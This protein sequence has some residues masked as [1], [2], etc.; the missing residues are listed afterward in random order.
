MGYDIGTI[1]GKIAAAAS[2]VGRP[3]ARNL[4]YLHF[5]LKESEMTSQ[6]KM[7]I[8]AAIA[9]VL[10]PNDF[11]PVKVFRLVGITDDAVAVMYVVRKVRKHITPAIIQKVEMILDQ[12]Y[13]YEIEFVE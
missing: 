1:F 5:V 10:V 13:G 9:Y 8:Y 3:I 7:W 12:W 6:Q 2:R 4:L 11:L